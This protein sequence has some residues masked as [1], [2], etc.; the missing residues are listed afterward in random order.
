MDISLLLFGVMIAAIAIFF[1][2][3]DREKETQRRFDECPHPPEQQRTLRVNNIMTMNPVVLNKVLPGRRWL[4][5]HCNVCGYQRKMYAP[6]LQ[7]YDDFVAEFNQ[8]TIDR[9]AQFNARTQAYL[10]D[11]EQAERIRK[12]K[13]DKEMYGQ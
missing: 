12:A 10:N 4:V 9:E 6:T 5:K 11:K 2:M 1:W 13:R 3:R 7:P 8:E